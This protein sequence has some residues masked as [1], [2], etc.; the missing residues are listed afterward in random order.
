MCTCMH[1][2]CSQAMHYCMPPHIV[3]T[4]IC[5]TIV[6]HILL[7]WKLMPPY[8]HINKSIYVNTHKA[9][10]TSLVQ[11]IKD[12]LSCNL[13]KEFRNVVYLNTW[14][15]RSNTW[16]MTNWENGAKVFDLTLTVTAC[17]SSH[18]TIRCRYQRNNKS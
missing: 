1:M 16:N 3:P 17:P 8:W 15:T 12:I 4:S 9:Q 11:N 7:W 18:L 14:K 2:G 6:C 5:I 10:I 13:S